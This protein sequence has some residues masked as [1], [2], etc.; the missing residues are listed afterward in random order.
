MFFKINFCPRQFGYAS[1]NIRI[2]VVALR[3]GDMSV[4]IRLINIFKCNPTECNH[5]DRTTVNVM[6]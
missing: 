4:E 3:I 1:F 6:L 2:M 5:V